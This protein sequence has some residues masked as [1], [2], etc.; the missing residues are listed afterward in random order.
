MITQYSY[1]EILVCRNV[2][3]S[4]EESPPK[5]DISG[6]VHVQ[7]SCLSLD[8]LAVSR[9]SCHP[10][11]KVAASLDTCTSYQ[12]MQILHGQWLDSDVRFT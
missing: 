4:I 9:Q 1:D 7:H 10:V 12:I 8:P 3:D 2:P 6:Y 5:K 11:V